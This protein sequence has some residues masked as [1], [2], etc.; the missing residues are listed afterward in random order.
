[1]VAYGAIALSGYARELGR[2]SPE[3]ASWFRPVLFNFEEYYDSGEALGFRV[4][5]RAIDIERKLTAKGARQ[6][7]L[8]GACGTGALFTTN[9]SFVLPYQIERI[10]ELLSRDVICMVALGTK[11]YVQLEMSKGVIER[12]RVVYVRFEAI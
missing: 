4:G 1:V 10:R 9:G 12:I 7:E 5:E 3:R 11:A 2:T 6:F 8:N